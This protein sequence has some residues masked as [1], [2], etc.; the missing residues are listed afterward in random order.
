MHDDNHHHYAISSLSG[1]DADHSILTSYTPARPLLSTRTEPTIFDQVYGSRLRRP[2]SI[3]L[4]SRWVPMTNYSST[5]TWQPSDV[6]SRRIKIRTCFDT[7]TRRQQ[8]KPKVVTPPSS[9]YTDAYLSTFAPKSSYTRRIY[10]IAAPVFA[11]VAPVTTFLPTDNEIKTSATRFNDANTISTSNSFEKILPTLAISNSTHLSSLTS[12]PTTKYE[13]IS[14]PPAELRTSE[15]LP[16]TRPTS[17]YDNQPLKTTVQLSSESPSSAI[18]SI[19]QVDL[20]TRK[21]EKPFPSPSSQLPSISPTI[22]PTKIIYKPAVVFQAAPS[23]FSKNISQF[24]ADE[25]SVESLSNTPKVVHRP[26]TLIFQ[27]DEDTNSSSLKKPSPLIT[28]SPDSL[29]TCAEE[30][31]TPELPSLTEEPTTASISSKPIEILEQTLNKYDT[32]IDQISSILA[33]VSPL[34][35]TVSSMSP[36]KSALDYEMTAD[37]SPVLSHKHIEPDL[38]SESTTIVTTMTTA[39]GKG[40]YLIRDDSY[41]KLLAT[42]ADLDN[43]LT[44]PPEN[45]NIT[46]TT[47]EQEAIPSE[48]AQSN[49]PAEMSDETSSSKKSNKRVTWGDVIVNSEDEESSLPASFTEEMTPSETPFFLVRQGCLGADQ[50]T[51]VIQQDTDLFESVANIS[52]VDQQTIFTTSMELVPPVIKRR[53]PSSSS[54]DTSSS[55]SDYVDRQTTSS[56][57]NESQSSQDEQI[58]SSASSNEVHFILP[59]IYPR[60][61]TSAAFSN[62]ESSIDTLPGSISTVHLSSDIDQGDHA[63]L[64]EVNEML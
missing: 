37:G 53:I 22:S 28:P 59:V 8:Q 10:R 50:S 58:I 3:G 21:V 9:D 48:P 20:S 63:S 7:T 1:F 2:I 44:P 25:R 17:F 15:T 41:D 43:E 5:Y 12:K 11:N 60:Q 13:P 19:D 14:N 23:P 45:E 47:V 46:T 33:S 27:P 29:N 62:I 26:E 40:K 49:T 51:T 16:L 38:P 31:T 32:I 24:A 30:K 54:L 56:E 55:V 42:I 4:N 57:F 35:S 6:Q 39:R 34:S 61:T 36:G 18:P 52:V 64:T